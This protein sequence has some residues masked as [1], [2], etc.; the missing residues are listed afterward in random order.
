MENCWQNCSFLL[1]LSSIPTNTRDRKILSNNKPHVLKTSVD[2]L[3][4]YVNQNTQVLGVG[5]HYY[6]QT[7]WIKGYWTPTLGVIMSINLSIYLYLHV[8]QNFFHLWSPWVIS[9]EFQYYQVG[10]AVWASLAYSIIYCRWCNF[11]ST[12]SPQH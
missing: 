1:S 7:N 9:L 8:S 11:K 2:W 10:G 5:H 3:Y 12:S 6:Q 4:A